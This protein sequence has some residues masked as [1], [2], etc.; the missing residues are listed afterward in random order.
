MARVK[1]KKKETGDR[2]LARN[3]KAKHDY[4]LRETW[5]AGLVLTGTEVKA[6]REGR[7][8]LK[9]GHVSI[10]H[11]EAFLVG[12][13]ISPYSFG[14]RENHPMERPRKL[15][16]KRKEIDRMQGHLQVKGLTVIPLSIFLKGPWIKVEI[17]LAQGKKLYDKRQAEKIKT[18]EKEAREAMTN[19]S[20]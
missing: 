6:I 10:K 15:L 13:S 3:R 16:M 17:A 9:D 14:G 19:R 5:E 7:V 11:G 1:K 2:V 8:Q 18:L 12:V 4:H 20:L